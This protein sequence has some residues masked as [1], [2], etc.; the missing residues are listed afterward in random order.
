MNL[1]RMVV[2]FALAMCVGI[3]ASAGIADDSSNPAGELD[4]Y[5]IYNALYSTAYASTDALETAALVDPWD[6]FSGSG[7]VYAE[8][9]FAGAVHTL[10][11]Y[12]NT[13]AEGGAPGA[14]TP[15]FTVNSSGLLASSPSASFSPTG[16]FGFYDFVDGTVDYTWYSEPGLNAD[17]GQDHMLLFSTPTAGVYMMAWEDKPIGTTPVSDMDYNDFVVQIEQSVVPEPASMVLLGIGLA[18]FAVRRVRQ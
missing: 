12:S 13:I 16:D 7:D 9:R 5:E 2:S 8:A 14:L 15:L 10:G 6:V 3:T 17:S 11:W 4:L 1:K 18:G